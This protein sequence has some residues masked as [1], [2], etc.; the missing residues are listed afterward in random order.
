MKKIYLL[1]SLLCTTLVL[2][3]QK[4]V[5]DANATTRNVR[6][7]HAIEIADGV[8]LYLTQSNE[9]AVAVSASTDEYRNRIRTEV[10]NGVLKIDFDQEGTW[11]LNWFGNR[12]LKAYVSIKTLDKLFASGGSD[13]FID[14]ELS[15]TRLTITLSGG[16]DFRGK[17]LAGELKISASGGSDAYIS[18]KAEQLSIQASGGSDVHGF[19]L[20]SDTCSIESSGGSDVRI[21]ANKEL[22]A[23]ASG[24]SDVYYKGSASSNTSKSGGGSIKKVD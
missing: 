24:G 13:V 12:K 8:D 15:A 22:R 18:G 19:E 2:N 17:V 3:A 16:S 11:K 14:K 7:F 5:H 6:N 4:T 23:S 9:E 1:F 10:V 20:V 21:T